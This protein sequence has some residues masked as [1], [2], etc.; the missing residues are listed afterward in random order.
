MP[1][2]SIA[3]LI[4]ELC[5]N[6]GYSISTLFTKCTGNKEELANKIIDKL[7]DSNGSWSQENFPKGQYITLDHH[8]YRTAERWAELMYNKMF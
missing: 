5:N 6:D 4:I 1:S 7:M 2:I 8:K 3:W